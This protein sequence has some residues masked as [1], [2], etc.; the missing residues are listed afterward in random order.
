M[1]NKTI[2][3]EGAPLVS[4]P[5]PAQVARIHLCVGGLRAKMGGG[6]HG[7]VLRNAKAV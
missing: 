6:G 5:Y 2:Q 3:E 1:L 4:T 7:E